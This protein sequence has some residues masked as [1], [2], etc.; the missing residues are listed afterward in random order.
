MESTLLV[1]VCQVVVAL[2]VANVWLVRAGRAT[3]YR[4]GSAR[5]L[6]EE[7]AVY[8]L[9][10]WAMPVVRVFK[11][12]FAAMLLA[13]LF[14]PVLTQVGAFGMAAFMLGAVAMHV[15]VKDDLKKAMPAT[16]MLLL[17]LFIGLA[18]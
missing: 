9:P 17:S 8:G 16:I 12:S 18:A 10:E 13:G 4:G 5:T 1:Q 15:K 14:V 7:F 6:R 11:L 3:P 2:V